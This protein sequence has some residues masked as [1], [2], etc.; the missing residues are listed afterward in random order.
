MT[1]DPAQRLQLFNLLASLPSAQFNGLLFAL[2]APIGNVSGNS[3][4][5]ADR[6]RDFL[7]W[8]ESPVGCG[9][10]AVM[11]L[12]EA[13]LGKHRTQPSSEASNRDNPMDSIDKSPQP[14]AWKE[15]LGNGVYLEM[16]NIP[17]GRFWMG[18][19]DSEAER[20]DNEGPVHSVMVPAFAIGKYPVTQAEWSEVAAL[21]KVA[22]ELNPF[23]SRFKGDRR[24]V[25]RVSWY[26]T[27]EFCERLSRLTHRA[28]RLP[29]EAE[30]EYACRART[31]TPFAFGETI[32][33]EQANYDGNSIYGAGQTGLYRECTTDVGSFPANQ[34][35]LQD[36]HGNVWEWCQDCWHSTY[37]G[38]PVDGSVW[39]EGGN[40][41]RRVLRGGSWL[42]Y[43]RNCRSASRI[44]FNPVYRY[45]SFGFRVVCVAPRAL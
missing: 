34:F 45:T 9:L 12:L 11:P 16:V 42:D 35:G 2:Q 5:P 38:A 8:A 41:D 43:P 36:M 20:A 13:I 24:P 39:T 3:A 25:E 29:S 7:A 28:Y 17:D 22:V 44:D 6:V 37:Q 23:P 21:P 33:P 32:S 10:D 30:W 19:P 15:H 4:P 31:R 18:S 1:T 40:P 27:V 14:K 26:E